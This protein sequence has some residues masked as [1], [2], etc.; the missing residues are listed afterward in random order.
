MRAASRGNALPGVAGGGAGGVASRSALSAGSARLTTWFDP[1]AS[2]PM[3]VLE[4]K[5]SLS[6]LSAREQKEVSLYLLRLRRESPAWRKVTAR[7]IREMQ[8]GKGTPI[9]EL[10]KCYA[11]G[12]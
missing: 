5:Q 7:R 9:E 8:A 10:E 4:I 1:L 2:T 12:K 3:S 11:G 6:R